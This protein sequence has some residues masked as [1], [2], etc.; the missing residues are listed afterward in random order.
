[1]KA[2]TIVPG[3]LLFV[4]H[5]KKNKQYRTHAKTLYHTFV[6]RVFHGLYM[7]KNELS[8]YMSDCVFTYLN[9]AIKRHYRLL[10]INNF[11]SFVVS[12]QMRF[13]NVARNI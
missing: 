1:M 2:L 11:I 9:A 12:A 7:K 4:Q 5:L 8:K 13:Y 10:K 3:V 6:Y